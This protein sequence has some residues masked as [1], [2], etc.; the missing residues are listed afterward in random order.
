MHNGSFDAGAYNDGANRPDLTEGIGIL[1]NPG[2]VL[3]YL[4]SHA[5]YVRRDAVLGLMGATGSPN[6]FWWNPATTDGH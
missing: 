3:L 1:H 2:S 5:N 6:E 4:D